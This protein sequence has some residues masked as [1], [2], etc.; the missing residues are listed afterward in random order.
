MIFV[1]GSNLAGIHGAGAARYAHSRLGAV[2]G[3]GLGRT[4]QCYALPTK[5]SRIQT[6]PL[7][8]VRVFVNRFLRHAHDHPEDEFKVTRV[9]CGLAG[10]KDSDIAPMFKGAPANCYFDSSWSPWLGAQH[11]YWGSA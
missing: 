1:F 4:G 2:Y 7:E 5:D 10:Y 8:G 6:L 11:K 3:E 9:G